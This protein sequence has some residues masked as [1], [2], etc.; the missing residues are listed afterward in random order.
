MNQADMLVGYGSLWIKNVL[1]QSV[2]IRSKITA[3]SHRT[4]NLK[5][6]VPDTTITL[7]ISWG[8]ESYCE[9]T[10]DRNV[11]FELL[12]QVDMLERQEMIDKG[13]VDV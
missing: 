6:Y 10:I 4:R 12:K 1:S 2:Q 11:L 5:K 7:S 3:R 13:V 9:L 8:L